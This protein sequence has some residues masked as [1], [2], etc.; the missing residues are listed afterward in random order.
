MRYY[1]VLRE[2]FLL[3]IKYENSVITRTK[4]YIVLKTIVFKICYFYSGYF[5]YFV[6]HY[7][8]KKIK[9]QKK[10]NVYL[11]LFFAI[12]QCSSLS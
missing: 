10:P 11:A 8:F 12:F 2:V 5:S 9:T 4:N 3:K 1:A 7:S 6:H